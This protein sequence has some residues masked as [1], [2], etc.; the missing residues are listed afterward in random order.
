MPG[1]MSGTHVGA[2]GSNLKE[3]CECDVAF[4]AV[5]AHLERASPACIA[6]GPTRQAVWTNRGTLLDTRIRSADQVDLEHKENDIE[7]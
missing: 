2:A 3:G 6:V 5:T 4:A 7:L 1:G